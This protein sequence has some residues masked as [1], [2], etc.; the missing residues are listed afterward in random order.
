MFGWRACGGGQHRVASPPS[1]KIM[2]LGFRVYGSM[3]S[4]GLYWDNGKENGNSH[5][6]GFRVDL[7]LQ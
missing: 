6:M 1:A 3:G 4:M 2:G 7:G 5:N